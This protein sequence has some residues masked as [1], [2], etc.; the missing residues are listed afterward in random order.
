MT[1][2]ELAAALSAGVD[3]AKALKR[4]QAVGV[5][6]LRQVSLYLPT[7]FVDLRRPVERFSELYPP[8]GDVVVVGRHAGDFETRWRPGR[9]TLIDRDGARLPFSLF[10]DARAFQRALASAGDGEIALAG[11]LNV[12]GNQVWLTNPVAIDRA[13]LG[14]VVPHYPGRSRVLAV[15]TARSLVTRLLPEAIPEAGSSPRPR[16]RNREDARLRSLLRRPRGTLE[17]LPLRHLPASPE[18]GERRG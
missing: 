16:A 4:L 1:G 3:P 2:P 14:H 17:D 5:E 18:E 12:A 6:S 13:L 7:R 10:G 15:A 9:G 11:A 8:S